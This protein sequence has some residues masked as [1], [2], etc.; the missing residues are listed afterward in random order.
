MRKGLGA[1]LALAVLLAGHGV[2]SAQKDKKPPAKEPQFRGKT[3]K[4]WVKALQG[5]DLTE[6]V[7]ALNALGEAGPEAKAAVPALIGMFRDKTVPFLHPIV[8]VRLA[9]IGPAA[10]PEL[11]KALKD[12][13]LL[14]R[15]GSALALSMLGPQASAA[16]PALAEALT[17]KEMLVR[18]T[19]ASA[20]AQ[21]GPAAKKAVPALRKALKDDEVSVRVEAADALWKVGREAKSGVA[22]L[23]NALA[24]KSA[25]VQQRAAQVLGEIGPPAK[26]AALALR[27][28]L[29]ARDVRV[30]IGAADALW[31]VAGD[32][33]AVLPVLENALGEKKDADVRRAAVQ[34]LGGMSAEARAISLLA[35]VLRREATPS[36][37]REAACALAD[38]QTAG[39]VDV[40][41]LREALADRD[42][43]VRW[44]AA[45]AL[46]GSKRDLRKLEDDIIAAL[47][48]AFPPSALTLDVLASGRARA[49]PALTAGLEGRRPRLRYEAARALGL[50]G[51]DARPA[52][53]ALLEA[54]KSDDKQVRRAAADS[55]G[56]VGR[57]V[58]PRLTKLLGSASPRVREGAAR[59]LGQVGPP[60]RSA[61]EALRRLLKDE[62]S[63]V[64]AQSAL[65]LWYIDRQSADA[66]RGLQLVL[67]DVDNPDRWEAVEG[68][69]I[70][71]EEAR[72][73]IR[74]LTEVLLGAVKDRDA[75]VRVWAV[76]G[77]WRRERV[78]RTAVPLLREA[79]TDRDAFVRR[80]ALEVL[81]EMGGDPRAVLLLVP[82]LD[83]RDPAVRF[84]ASEGLLRPGAK[85]VQE[86][87]LHLK[88]KSARVRLGIVRVLAA[89]GDQA[90]AALP[91]LRLAAEEDKDEEVRKAAGE[92][93]KKI[94]G[95][96]RSA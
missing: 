80:T 48:S 49:I 82:A 34:V 35:R 37:R 41:V 16:V 40:K 5:K 94:A 75:R 72:P 8:A 1:C 53:P 31:K 55:L 7:R 26:E 3:V 50:L 67:K 19:A 12:K 70:I 90:K 59:A 87:V 44:W 21:V 93:V 84:A 33:K 6:R 38:R 74:G 86:L 4:E 65:A 69:S 61:V 20:L 56:Q 68:L 64:R 76:R 23:K 85:G 58:I 73:P 51:A 71:A 27:A 13:L 83:D 88:N 54:L 81:G 39:K 63:G 28:A 57:E 9:G 10:V 95:A 29:K 22:A 77:L 17:D 78:V 62:S 91:A 32:G 18:T 42:V 11:S 15:S 24:N 36:V 2:T 66:L 14:V 92:A 89:L 43:G 60:A 79:V 47:H 30:R 96:K 45:V 52:V 25:E 46:L